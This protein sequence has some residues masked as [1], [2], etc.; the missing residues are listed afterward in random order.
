M[1]YFAK[2]ISVLFSFLV[3]S[4]TYSDYKTRMESKTMF[5]F[6]LI[7]WSLIVLVAL[8]YPHSIDLVI[9]HFRNKMGGIGTILGVAIVL[10]FYITYKIYRKANRIEQQ[11]KVLVRN[12]ALEKIKNEKKSI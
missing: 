11:M 5:I 1:I 9:R 6:W 12:I 4:R 8:S 3:I 7:I 10:L 2:V